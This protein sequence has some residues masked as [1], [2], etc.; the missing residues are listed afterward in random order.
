MEKLL[1]TRQVSEILQVHLNSL[2]RMVYQKRIPFT[3]VSGM[4]RFDPDAL[5][6]WIQKGK[7]EPEDWGSKYQGYTK[8]GEVKN[9]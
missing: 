5:E 6:T 2:Y 4:L 9:E 1:T 3:K 7:V 8:V